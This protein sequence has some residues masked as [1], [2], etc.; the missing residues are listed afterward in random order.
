MTTLEKVKDYYTNDLN[1][2]EDLKTNACCTIVKY[3]ENIKKLIAN[4]H[5][6]VQNTYYGCGLVIPDCLSNCNVLDLGCGTGFDV[7]IVSQ[8]VGEN[9]SIIGVDMTEKQL[10]VANKWQDWQLGKFNYNSSNVEFKLRPKF[11]VVF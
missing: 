11:N 8:L 1:C 3:P 4:I 5:E 2:S 10:Q 7:Y 9:G 6:D